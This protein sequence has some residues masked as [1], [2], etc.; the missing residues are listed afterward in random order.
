VVAGI[1]E[2]GAALERLH[3]QTPALQRSHE[4]QRHRGLPAP[5]RLSTKPLRSCARWSCGAPSSA[6]RVLHRGCF[7]RSTIARSAAIVACS[8]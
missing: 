7:V 2:V 5:L 6:I 4:T 3:D 1:D 8:V